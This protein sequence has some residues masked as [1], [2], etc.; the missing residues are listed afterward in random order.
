MEIPNETL[1][2]WQRLYDR[3]DAEQIATRAKIH[4]NTYFNTISKRR[5]SPKLLKIMYE[6]FAEKEIKVLFI[7]CRNLYLLKT[8]KFTRMTLSWIGQIFQICGHN[9][10]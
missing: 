6:F 1:A 8:F 5:G 4:K 9:L 10:Q 3:G 2:K 7:N